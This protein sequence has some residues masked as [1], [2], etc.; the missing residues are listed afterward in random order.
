MDHARR[1]GDDRRGRRRCAVTVAIWVGGLLRRRPGRLIGTAAGIAVA[2]ALL[3]CLGAFLTHSQATMTDRAVR[4]VGVDWQV[5]V[6]SGADPGAVGRTLRATV[7]VAGDAA[8]GFGS[9]TGLSA[10]T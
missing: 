3:A 2:V 6:R 10:A 8:V 7:G 5:Q 9:S 1:P 4:G